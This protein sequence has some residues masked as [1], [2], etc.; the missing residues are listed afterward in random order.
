MAPGH[1]ETQ[2]ILELVIGIV[3]HEER[4]EVDRSSN[5]SCCYKLDASSNIFDWTAKESKKVR[6][7]L[8]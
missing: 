8:L 6:G 1:L 4:L 2:A 3:E 7:D 5:A